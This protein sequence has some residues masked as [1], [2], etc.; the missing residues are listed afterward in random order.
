MKPS[1]RVVSVIEVYVEI[2]KRRV[3]ACP[4]EWPAWERSGGDVDSALE[5]LA[6]YHPRY[7]SALGD[8]GSLVP[9]PEFMVVASLEGNATTDYGAP[10]QIYEADDRPLRPDGDRLVAIVQAAWAA[11]ERATEA[12][13]LPLTKGPRGGGRELGAIVAHVVDAERSY[14]PKIGV[15]GS[16]LDPR[17]P[18]AVAARRDEMITAAL[19]AGPESKWPA[20]FFL[21]RL[22]WHALDHAWEIED[23]SG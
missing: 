8:L 1:G 19:S 3:F 22:A 11:V 15:R 2:G 23:R 7:V 17:D 4:V 20:R 18:S 6:T 16:Q 12:A 13:T 21:R 14:A 9:A 10:G 5:N